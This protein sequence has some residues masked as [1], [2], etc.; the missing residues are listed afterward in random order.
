MYGCQTL[1]NGAWKISHLRGWL[2]VLSIKYRGGKLPVLNLHIKNIWSVA[3]LSQLFLGFFVVFFNFLNWLGNYSRRHYLS[4]V[5]TLSPDSPSQ[6]YT[7]IKNRSKL[8][9]TSVLHWGVSDLGSLQ[10][11]GL[12]VVTKQHHILLQVSH[13]PVFMV[14]HTIL[15]KINK[16]FVWHILLKNWLEN[17]HF[18]FCTSL[19]SVESLT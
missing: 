4:S 17:I 13:T 16:L 2:I 8:E 14:S 6:E 18:L 9:K 5:K 10:V 19:C 11:E 1:T 7:Q 12:G 15:M 3:Q